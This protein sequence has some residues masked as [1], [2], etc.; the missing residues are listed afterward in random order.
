MTSKYK[1]R[2]LAVALAWNLSAAAFGVEPDL[3]DSGA[4]F[5]DQAS[6]VRVT[7]AHLAR[8]G[9]AETFTVGEVGSVT[10][11]DDKVTLYH[12]F[13]LQPRGFVVVAADRELPPV[14]AYS[15]DNDF[16]S[17]LERAN[18]L[19]AMLRADLKRRLQNVPVLPDAVRRVRH[20]AWA[21]LLDVTPTA[22]DGRLLEQWPAPGTTSTGGWIETNWDQDPPYNNYC[23]ID[24][25]SG[26]RSIAGCP[27]VA[28]AQ[29]LNYHERINGT[30]FDDGDDYYHNYGGNQYWIDNDYATYDFPSF[31]ELNGY[32]DTLED[33]YA[34][35]IALTASDKAALT[36]ACGVAATQ[37]Y[38]PGG[39][40]TFGVSQAMAAYTKFSC[41]TAEL[42]DDGDADVYDRLAQNMKDA[43]PAHLA[44]VNAEWTSGHNVV[45][46]G[47]NSDDYF[48]LN[49]GWGGPYNGW[50]LLPDEFPYGLT[51]LEGVIVDIMIDG[52]DIPT[53]SA[54]GVIVMTLLAL[55]A[56]T[57]VFAGRRY[58]PAKAG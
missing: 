44:V 53:V 48:H 21:E 5:V 18:P 42:L 30:R 26:S 49:F 16:G 9:L 13:D 20:R 10:N 11:D 15:F 58:V 28:M 17:D 41:T 25:S 32:L 55:V 39:S 38:N 29:I 8:H 56:G 22:P 52:D 50:Y 51:V 14:I 36:F 37:V 4:S 6:A 2:F 12:R 33:H 35:G 24:L 7:E 3:P 43:Y 1:V 31:P 34:G 23:P 46:D 54:W 47:Y 19:A 45:V 40:G 27:S 57:V